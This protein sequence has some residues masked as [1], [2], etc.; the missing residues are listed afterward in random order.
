MI[1]AEARRV[2]DEYGKYH[3][4]F[5]LFG[6]FLNHDPKALGQNFGILFDEFMPYRMTRCNS[7]T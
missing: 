7:L 6:F 3:K 2:V 1:R 4:A 5:A